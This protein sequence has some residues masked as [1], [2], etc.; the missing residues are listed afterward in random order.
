MGLQELPE[1]EKKEENEWQSVR[2]LSLE[3][4]ICTAI[5]ILMRDGQEQ[6][7]LLRDTGHWGS[8]QVPTVVAHC[9][10]SKHEGQQHTNAMGS[11]AHFLHEY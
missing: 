4:N 11:K 7:V 5:L 2:L 8:T 3:V 10:L 1:K 6:Q 9:L